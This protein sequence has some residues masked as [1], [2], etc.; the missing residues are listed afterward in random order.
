MV[1]R[2]W[3]GLSLAALFVFAAA[4]SDDPAGPG[5]L[6]GNLSSQEAADVAEG[7]A[8][9]M[10]GILDGEIAAR[11]LV[12]PGVGEGGSQI[13]FSMAPVVTEFEFTRTRECRNGGTVVAAGS[14]VHTADRETGIVTLD[15][16]GT[17]TITECARAR[18]DLVIT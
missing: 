14:G 7:V 13:A 12:A 1:H 16:S 2:T 8:D 5:E 4:C 10:D 18:G 11:P 9:A 17:K 3:K 15:F 6:A